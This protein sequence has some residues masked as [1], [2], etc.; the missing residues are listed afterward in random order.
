MKMIKMPTHHRRPGIVLALL[1][2]ARVTVGLIADGVHV[3]PAMLALAV[4]VA[5][6]GRV[7]LTSDATAAAGSPAGRYMI[8]G[9]ETFSDGTSA[10]L[11]DGTLAGSAVT[12]NRMV[13]LMATL[14]GLTLRDA[15]EMATL[16]PAR[17]LGVEGESGV[18]RRGARADLVILDNDHRVKLTLVAGQVAFSAGGMDA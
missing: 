15:V 1:L 8:A 7:A 3:H 13:H 17:V 16:T 6:P 5:G 9:R 14:P 11:A 4:K 10:R 12:M 18:L 2:D